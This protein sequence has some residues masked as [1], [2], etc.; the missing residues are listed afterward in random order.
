MPGTP[1]AP[2]QGTEG[3]HFPSPGSEAILMN[4]KAWTPFGIGI[5]A[6][7]LGACDLHRSD[8]V[9][10]TLAVMGDS[11]ATRMRPDRDGRDRQS[12]IETP[13]DV[14]GS[15]QQPAVPATVPAL[16]ARMRDADDVIVS[17]G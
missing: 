15:A 11:H 1:G 13:A 2:L 8:P 7:L 6:M 5:G 12:R 4:A 17:G 9:P 16:E 10:E 14:A 3:R